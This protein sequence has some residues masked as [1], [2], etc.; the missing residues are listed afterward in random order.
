V[1]LIEQP[2]RVASR[3]APA[4]APQLDAAW[5]AVIAQLRSNEREGLPLIAGG[6]SMGARVACRTAGACGAL[7][8]LCL[9]RRRAGTSPVKTRLSEL[10]LLAVPTLVVQGDRDPFGIPPEAANRTVVLVHGDHNLRKDH[11]AIAIAISGWLEAVLP[12]R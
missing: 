3:R 12:P 2:Y 4:P 7:A 9:A 1:A 10:D 5:L 6:R 8:V 11:A